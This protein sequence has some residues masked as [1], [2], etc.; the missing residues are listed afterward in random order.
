MLYNVER[1]TD[2]DGRNTI[3]FEMTS[4]EADGLVTDGAKRAKDC[5]LRSIFPNTGQYFRSVLGLGL[6]LAVL[7]RHTMKRAV[8]AANIPSA[9]NSEAASIG[10]KLA[11][12]LVWV[13]SLSHATLSVKSFSG[14]GET[15]PDHTR[16]TPSK[17]AGLAVV[18][19]AT[20]NFE[21]DLAGGVKGT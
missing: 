2:D 20:R 8:N 5:S 1:R 6:A 21:S 10:K 7:C 11:R 16:F 17:C 4:H 18:I 19:S 13:N 15:A 3:R 9:A 12:S 14:G